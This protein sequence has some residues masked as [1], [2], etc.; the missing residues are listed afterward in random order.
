[1]SQPIHVLIVEDNP[2]DAELLL[3]A[4]RKGGYEPDYELVQTAATMTDAL[5]NHRW[6]IIISDYV[7]PQFSAMDAL[8]LRQERAADAPFIVV[9]GTIGEDVAVEAIKAGADDYLMK[10][11]LARLLP[12]ID[13]ALREAEGRRQRLRA[14]QALLASEELFRRLSDCSPVGILLM[15]D[16]GHCS[17]CNPRGR[18]IF[19]TGPMGIVGKGWA[20][21]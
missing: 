12:A 6:D 14:E 10:D 4:L 11:K 20:T 2:K 13:R 18:A 7:M 3:R 5:R 21:P 15:D 19:G 17:Y 9:S 1:M 16:N 8:Q